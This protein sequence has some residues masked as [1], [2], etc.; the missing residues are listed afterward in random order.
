MKIVCVGGGPAGLYFASLMKLHDA[1]HDVTVLERNPAGVTYGWGVVFWDDLLEQL[2]ESDAVAAATITEEAF[3]WTGQLLAVQGK[4]PVH[5]GGHGYGIGRQQLLDILTARATAL[6]VDVRFEHEVD[7]PAALDDADVIVACDGVNSRLRQLRADVFKPT[8][9]VGRNKYVW[10]G[11]TRVFDAFTFAFVETDSGWIWCHAY[12]FD[13]STS[14]F[15]VECSP[16]TWTGLGFDRLGEDESIALLERLF[17]SQLDGQPL[18]NQVRSNDTLPWLNFRRVTNEQWRAGK[19]VLMGDAAHTTHF[20]IGSGTK[21]ALEDSIRLAA[22]LTEHADVPAAFEA[23]ER[24]RKAELLKPQ[25]EARLSAQWFEN[26]T[27]YVDLDPQ[28]FFA[29]LKERRSLIL[30]RVPPR[31]YYRLHRAT[32]NIGWLHRLREWMGPRVSALYNRGSALRARR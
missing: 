12:G 4:E 10:L 1:R 24:R 16:E 13:R 21:L 2:R 28:Q 7:D 26:I 5:V 9:A 23:Y 18:K 25:T 14:T 31:S 17:A 20:T 6:G 30:P 3:G 11:T 27:R 29:L 22:A 8:V 32:Q 19:V 15:I